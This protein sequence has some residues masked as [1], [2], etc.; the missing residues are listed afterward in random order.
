MTAKP[1]STNKPTASTAQKNRDSFFSIVMVVRNDRGISNSLQALEPVV[2]QRPNCEV[3]VV[4]ASTHTPLRDIAERFSWVH[5]VPFENK[6]GKRFTITEQRN[7][8]IKAAR[9]DVIIFL[10]ANCVPVPDWLDVFERALTT[11]GHDVATGPITS[12]GENKLHDAGYHFKDNQVV[13]ECGAANLA[14]RK[15]VLEELGGFDETMSY[16]EDVDLT[17]RARTLGYQIIFKKDAAIAHD[18]GE[19]RE[20]LRRAF[21]YGASRTSLYKKHPREL[22]RLAGPDVNVLIYPTFLLLLP[23]T[24]WFPF[25]PLLI[26][27]PLLKNVRNHAVPSTT[28]H[29]VYGAGVLKGIFKTV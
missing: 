28:L 29:L 22:K 18:W 1:K 25:Y 10:D 5:W 26:V 2:K 15:K 19:F 24:I 27:V 23:L 17:W 6:T 8:G 20:E 11:E 13:S 4:D 14:I 9:G 7:L 16:G 21:R 12:I 3:I